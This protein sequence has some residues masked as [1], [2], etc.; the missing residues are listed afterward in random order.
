MDEYS[1]RAVLVVGPPG[2]GK[3]RLR[4]E[5]MRRVESQG[6]ELLV[7]LGQGDPIRSTSNLGMLGGAVA[8][9]CGVRLGSA[10]DDDRALFE[11]RVGRHLNEQQLRTTVFLG[12]ICGI[13]WPAEAVPE[14]R[15]ARQNPRIMSEQIAQAFIDFLRAEA[16][17]HPVVLVLDDLQ[18]SDVLTVTL[19]DAALRELD[20]SPLFVLAMAR[21]EAQSLFPHLWASHL[22]II[23]L[24]PL[25]PAVAA[26]FVR[27][28]LGEGVRDDSVDRIVGRAAGNA[29]YLEELIRAASAHREAIPETVLAMLQARIGLLSALSRRVLRAASVFG[30]TFTSAAVEALLHSTETHAELQATLSGLSRDEILEAQG[31][32]RW[33]FRHVLMRDAAYS[34]FTP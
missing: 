30:E 28:V 31:A 13:R 32:E 29:L 24:R 19:V 5:L 2:M 20:R 9:E 15:A 18:W 23:P 1:T 11:E 8:R 34:L 17:A 27:Q 33:R 26:R 16:R 21:P 3:T 12:E 6:Q 14:L 25:A 10:S 7:L 4:H 22:A